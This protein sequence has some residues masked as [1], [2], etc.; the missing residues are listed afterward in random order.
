MQE[1]ACTRGDCNMS[2]ILYS[3]NMM[4]IIL[5]STCI[6]DLCKFF[7]ELLQDTVPPD[8][9]TM[10]VYLL[11]IKNMELRKCI[12]YSAITKQNLKK[13]SE[14]IESDKFDLDEIIGILNESIT[15]H[16]IAGHG[17]LRKLKRWRSLN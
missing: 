6:G 14:K 10:R 1:T 4:R 12:G 3:Y 15:L 5:R 17:N 8:I 13:I 7:L 16:D 9:S 11:H 2:T